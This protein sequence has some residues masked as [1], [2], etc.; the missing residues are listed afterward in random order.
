MRNDEF[1]DIMSLGIS[2]FWDK[3]L[4][5]VAKYA[6]LTVLWGVLAAAYSEGIHQALETPLHGVNQL[7]C[8]WAGL[9]QSI[10]EKNLSKAEL[11]RRGCSLGFGFLWDGR[12]CSGCRQT[13]SKDLKRHTDCLVG[14]ITPDQN[15]QSLHAL[16]AFGVYASGFL[17]R[18]GRRTWLDVWFPI[19]LYRRSKAYSNSTRL[20]NHIFWSQ[21]LVSQHAEGPRC[22]QC[23]FVSMEKPL[24]CRHQ[25][26]QIRS[27]ERPLVYCS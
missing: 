11:Y 24:W 25:Q 6:R 13:I 4:T 2:R 5:W 19:M 15:N 7:R 23:H 17:G 3:G 9:E 10:L 8:L 12:R 26:F 22:H 21:N 18:P 20:S 16:L 1:R 14:R 27:V